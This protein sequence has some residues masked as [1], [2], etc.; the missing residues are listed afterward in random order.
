MRRLGVCVAELSQGLV[1]GRRATQGETPGPEGIEQA[2][3]E[4][5]GLRDATTD[6]ALS[7]HGMSTEP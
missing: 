4:A 1:A 5:G 6:E 7:L 2:T 3:E